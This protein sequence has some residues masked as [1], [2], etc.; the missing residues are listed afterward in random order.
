MDKVIYREDAI[1]AVSTNVERLIRQRGLS[2]RELARQSE[3][4]PIMI[5][6]LLRKMAL[7]SV[8]GMSR[9]AEV[10]GTTVDHLLKK[11]K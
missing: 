5:S 9:I 7:P 8:D 6:R 11:S 2:I 4:D 3:T 1:D 10:L